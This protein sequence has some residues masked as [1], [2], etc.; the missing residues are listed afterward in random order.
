MDRNGVLLSKLTTTNLSFFTQVNIVSSHV[1][2]NT[3]ATTQIRRRLMTNIQP[4]EIV[5]WYYAEIT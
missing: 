2:S 5:Y 3:Q 1:R 4:D